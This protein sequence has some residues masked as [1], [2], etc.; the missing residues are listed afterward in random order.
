[1]EVVAFNGSP[2][3]EGNTNFALKTV[4]Q[5]LK[6]HGIHFEI[7]QVGNKPICGCPACQKF[8]EKELCIFH[9]EV[10][11]W[12]EKI[13]KAEGILLGSPTYFGGIAGNM[14]CFLD[15]A[16]YVL[17]DKAFSSVMSRKVGAAVV[18]MARSGGVPVWDNL[19]NY[20][21]QCQ[22]VVPS[23]NGFNVIFGNEPG[24]ARY[25]SRGIEIMRVLGKNM[26]HLM[27]KIN[28]DAPCTF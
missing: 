10:D 20:F 18:A 11:L 12:I 24:T 22:V 27:K 16:F 7:I 15:R 13:I 23:S 14:K 8:A 26:A 3:E 19:N 9:D 25:D 5:E 4:G 28:T 6:Q 1:M 2:N 17:T 21:Q